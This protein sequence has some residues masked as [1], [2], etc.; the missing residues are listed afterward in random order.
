MFSAR[1]AALMAAMLLANGGFQ[2]S[3]APAAST[4]KTAK[5]KPAPAK[6]EKVDVNTADAKT[7]ETL[8][9]IGPVLADKIIAGRPYRG[10]A[11]LKNVKGLSES[12]VD[13]IKDDITFSRAQLTTK[14]QNK[15]TART[16]KPLR[17]EKAAKSAETAEP[18]GGTANS[19]S[20][21]KQ[22]ALERFPSRTST[23]STPL[24]TQGK[25]NINSATAEELDVLPGIGPVKAQSIIEY[26]R[27]QGKFKTIEEI[28]NVKGIKSGE[29]LKIKDR[30]KVTD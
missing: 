20:V 13:A 30:I 22:G 14:P 19:G 17:E 24:A 7:I 29:F 4:N 5:I 9:G 15:G 2:A 21:T 25:I 6:K 16:E 3:A 26:R 28:E 18:K 10:L 11:D 8:P 23:P 27:Q 12:K 1:L